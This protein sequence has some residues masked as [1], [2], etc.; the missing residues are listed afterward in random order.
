[1]PIKQVE[2]EDEVPEGS[3]NESSAINQQ[4]LQEK[5]YPLYKTLQRIS[6][7]MLGK[8]PD[9]NLLDCLKPTLKQI[10]NP[11]HPRLLLRAVSIFWFYFS[12][13]RV[14]TY[15]RVE[16]SRSTFQYILA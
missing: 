12:V 10:I 13:V 15:L 16:S 6:L 7:A 5:P 11:K 2:G 1:M 8:A 4:Y 3:T 14:Q 9:K